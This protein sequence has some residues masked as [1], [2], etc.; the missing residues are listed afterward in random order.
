[1]KI[2]PQFLL[3]AGEGKQEQSANKVTSRRLSEG[4]SMDEKMDLISGRITALFP[5]PFFNINVPSGTQ[6]IRNTAPSA[7]YTEQHVLTTSHQSGAA[8]I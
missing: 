7:G 2:S 6:I 5:S 1:M 8:V 3:T 4:K